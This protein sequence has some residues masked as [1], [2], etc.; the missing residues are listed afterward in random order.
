MARNLVVIPSDLLW[1]PSQVRLEV[2]ILL[3]DAQ[4]EHLNLDITWNHGPSNDTGGW[5]FTAGF[6]LTLH[7]PYQIC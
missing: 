1:L 6:L 2:V 4:T 3:V 7:S 5:N